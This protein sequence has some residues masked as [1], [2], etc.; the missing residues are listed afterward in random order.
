MST[1]DSKDGPAAEGA[2][3]A[4]AASE[5]ASAETKLADAADAAAPSATAVEKSGEVG[6]PGEPAWPPREAA[7][8]EA[9]SA[10]DSQPATAEAPAASSSPAAD[11]DSA[12]PV[13]E[14]GFSNSTLHW[15]ADGDASRPTTGTYPITTPSFDPTA[16]VAGR[17]R[18][19]MVVG[20]AA[21]VAFLV[22]GTL[23]FQAGRHRAEPTANAPDPARDLVTRAESALAANRV[24]EALDLARLALVADARSADAHFVVATCERARNNPA[25]AR[26]EFRRYLA[27]APLGT[28]AEA[29]RA[30]LAELPP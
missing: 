22:A 10:G 6:E 15:L 9:N 20:G 2:V 7:P 24:G 19:V 25:A 1:P 8:A 4:A 27:L 3:V 29:A 5:H 16:P 11:R 26:D 17:R 14:M 28:H 30:A 23:Y 18:A 21:I 12:L 13:E